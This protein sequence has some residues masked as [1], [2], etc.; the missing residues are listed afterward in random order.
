MED[1]PTRLGF[2][3][4]VRERGDICGAS[5]YDN[6]IEWV[7]TSMSGA[8]KTYCCGR[9]VNALLLS[10][11]QD[12]GFTDPARSKHATKVANARGN[13]WAAPR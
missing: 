9:C 12:A 6:D 4:N 1:A 3:S 7:E 11:T 2:C 5:I 8:R 10:V 13:K